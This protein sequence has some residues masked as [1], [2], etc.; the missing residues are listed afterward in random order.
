M[1]K[2]EIDAAA[3]RA[4]EDA[5]IRDIVKFQED[6]GLRGITD[7]EFRRTYFHIDFLTQLEGVE[8]KGGIAISFH[9]NAGNVDFAPPVMH[10][11]EEGAACEADPA[12]R[13]RVP[14]VGDEAHAEGDDPLAHDAALPRGPEGHQPGGLPGDGGLL[15]RH[16]A[17]LPR[18]DRRPG[19]RRLHLPAARRHQ[20]RLPVRHED[21]RGREGARRRSRTSCRAATR[22]SSTPRSRTGPR[23]C[24]SASTCAAATSRAR[25]RPKAATSRSPRCCSTQLEVD[26]YF[27]EYDDARSGDFRPLRHVPKDKTVVLGLVSTKLDKMETKDEL[28]RRIDEAAKF[29]P[30]RADVPSRRSAASARPC[31]AT[32]SRSRRRPPRSGSA[33]TPRATCGAAYETRSRSGWSATARSARSSRRSS[34]SRRSAGSARGTS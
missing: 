22:R 13:L 18:R 17:G 7:G 34:S 28:K 21:A 9:S 33:S 23:R 8:T 4:V 1:R 24:G 20:P 31:T 26:G 11:T 14:E 10:V 25:G 19:R 29:M 32:R 16:R 27:L 15:R 30:R 12:P 2:G 6:L 5:A 3:L